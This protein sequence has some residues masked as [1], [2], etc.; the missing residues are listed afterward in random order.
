MKNRTRGNWFIFARFGLLLILVIALIGALPVSP[1]LAQG[2]GP[3]VNTLIDEA[4][5]TCADADCSLRDAV[6]TAP[7]DSTITFAVSGTITLNTALGQLVVNRGLTI[8]GSSSAPGITISGNNGTRVFFVTGSGTTTFNYLKIT[9]GSGSGGQGGGI[10]HNGQTLNL[11]NSHVYNNFAPY[12]GG[13]IYSAGNPLNIT[14][15]AITN[16]ITNY[17]GGGIFLEGGPVSTIT[18]TTIAQNSATY[19]GGGVFLNRPTIFRNTTI[20]YNTAGYPGGGIFANNQAMFYN[21]ILAYNRSINYA[22]Q[23]PDCYG[24]INSYGFSIVRTQGAY[25]PI[26]QVANPGT[27]LINVD[28]LLG[29][30]AADAFPAPFYP[31]QVSSPALNLVPTAVSNCNTAPTS[32]Q[33]GAYRPNGTAPVFTGQGCDAGAV[34]MDYLTSADP[35][36]EAL[37]ASTSPVISARLSAAPDPSTVWAGNFM[38][39]GKQSGRVLSG[40]GVSTDTITITPPGAFLPGEWVQVS[41][42]TR[43]LDAYRLSDPLKGVWEFRVPAGPA[44][45]QF[46]LGQTLAENAANEAVLGDVD[47]DDDLDIV[48]ANEGGLAST[49]WKNDGQA[50]FNLH[51]SLPVGD[52]TGANL[53]DLDGDGDLDLLFTNMS[54]PD[55]EEIFRNDGSGNFSAFST[56]NDGI[57]GSLDSAVG[58]LD[59]DA[60]LDVIVVNHGLNLAV[61]KNNGNGSMSLS[62]TFD[63]TTTAVSVGLGDVDLDGDLDAISY[64]DGPAELYLNDGSGVFSIAPSSPTFGA[65]GRGLV[66]GDFSGDRYPDVILQSGDVSAVYINNRSGRFPTNNQLLTTPFAS[67]GVLADLDGDGDLDFAAGNSSDQD[68]SDETVWLNDGTGAFSA[69]PET[70]AF[71]GGISTLSMTAGDL[72]GDERIDLLAAN[73]GGDPTTFWLN[74]AP[75]RSDALSKDGTEDQT[76]EFAAEDFTALYSDPENDPVQ[77]VRIQTL[78]EHGVLNLGTEPVIAGQVILPGSLGTLNFVPDQDWNGDTTFTFQ[79]SDWLLYSADATATLHFA[80]QDDAPVWSVDLTDT[81]VDEGGLLTIDLPVY[82]SDVD[83]PAG[84]LVYSFAS[85]PAS[86]GM[87]LDPT[88]HVFTWTPTEA[89]GPGTYNVT[90]TVSDGTTPVDK[91]IEIEVEEV[92]QPPV[93]DAIDAQEAHEAVLLTVTPT[94]HDDDQPANTLQFRLGDGAPSGMAV[95]PATGVITWTPGEDQGG[96]DYP[97]TLYLSDQTGE[98]NQ[99]VSQSFTVTVIETNQDPYFVGLVDQQVVALN[100]LTFTVAGDDDDLPEQALTYGVKDGLLPD[101][102]SF[103][104]DT[105]IFTWTPAANQVGEF[106]V[107]FTVT[108]G[109]ATAEHAVKVTV[110]DL[111]RVYLPLISR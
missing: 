6:N 100:L 27:N 37:A 51:A 39:H 55:E 41:A 109:E 28:P 108:D 11:N 66:V 83:T 38:V 22:T 67:S 14:N 87:T 25:C 44:Q 4:D 43:I 70:P 64:G 24:P 34:E 90:F 94:F 68:P 56:F 45:A 99:E 8:T 65:A 5:G 80:P 88:T 61:F 103:D 15:S 29:S 40:F 60:D 81:S 85:V 95:D 96:A 101:G 76:L 50:Q 26:N 71:S 105:Q 75:P 77:A 1:A 54:E 63:A 79:V 84:S 110:L 12:Y 19:E 52:R 89:E 72:N 35:L 93:L 7:A 23:Y 86:A 10:M 20:A 42:S 92:N 13:G 104:P 107:T 111:Y 49:V 62:G 106:T 32:D 74:D 97:V 48:F 3:V 36:P 78:P 17:P 21:T 58:D 31:L 16:N 2:T 102:A 46:H 73:Y 30:L 59:G 82:A 33:R 18:N 53:A 69:A 98:P 47:G 91:A 9:N 57:A